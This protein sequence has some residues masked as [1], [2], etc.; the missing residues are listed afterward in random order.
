MAESGKRF[1][2]TRPEKGR[3]ASYGSEKTG[4]LPRLLLVEDI[5]GTF[6]KYV[7]L[8]SSGRWCGF[9]WG[10]VRFRHWPVVFS[11]P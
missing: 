8:S 6:R 9:S 5:S 11:L 7:P 4:E 1:D 10:L 3:L 2:R